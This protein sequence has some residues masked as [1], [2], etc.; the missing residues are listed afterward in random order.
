MLSRRK[1]QNMDREAIA[2]LGP[3]SRRRRPVEAGISEKR[4]AETGHVPFIQF[5]GISSVKAV[6]LELCIAS[7]TSTREAGG[8]LCLQSGALL[9]QEFVL[10]KQPLGSVLGHSFLFS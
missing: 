9:L 7:L 3:G 6:M 10:A 5:R 2:I 4:P 1:T 8:G